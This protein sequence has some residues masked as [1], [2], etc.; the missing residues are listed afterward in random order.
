MIAIALTCLFYTVAAQTK[1]YC[2]P[3]GCKYDEKDFD[4][5]GQCPDCGMKLLKRGTY[6][7]ETPSVSS[8]GIIIYKSNKE[9]YKQKLYYR[10]INKVGN[11]KRLDI[12][13][14]PLIS[15]NGQQVL[16]CKEGD[17]IYVYDIPSGSSKKLLTK[18]AMPGL[19]TPAWD[20]ENR[21]IYFAAGKFP[22]IGVYQ[23]IT[24][25]GQVKPVVNDSALRYGISASP[26]GTHIA[27]RCA[28]PDGKGTMNKG[29]AVFDLK[30]GTEKW[31]TTMGEYPCWSPNSK[32]VA[33]HWTDNKIYCLYVVNADGSGLKKLT[34]TEQGDCELPVWSA[35]GKKIYFQTNRR[36]GNWEIWVMNTDG[37]DQRSLIDK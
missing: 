11:E 14:M 22:N 30:A 6:N 15:R 35:D 5:A 3:C 31:I 18:D 34:T 21:N 25:T 9:N 17:A 26:N 10:S 33:F 23:F 20:H 13:D 7:Y 19:Q 4:A 36:Q 28:K 12:D 27:Y 2:S 16:Y 37:G 32:Q 1:Y 29:I 8:N 24:S